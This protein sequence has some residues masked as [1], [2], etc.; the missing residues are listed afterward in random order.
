MHD[1]AVHAS[2]RATVLGIELML[3]AA[4]YL[5]TWHIAKSAWLRAEPRVI[6]FAMVVDLT[7]TAAG[8]HWLLGVRLARVPAWTVIL[9]VLA[10]L[11]TS[12]R[13]LPQLASAGRL[14]VAGIALIEGSAVMLGVFKLRHFMRGYRAARQAEA[15]GFDAL[16]AGF[17]A[18][19]P[20][21]PRLAAWARLEAEIASLAWVGWFLDRRPPDG[22]N[23]FTHHRQSH[24]LTIIGVLTFLVIVEGSGVHL[25]LHS[26]GHNTAKWILSAVHGYSLIWLLGDAQAARLYRSALLL[27]RGEP[28]LALQV[29]L[30][31]AAEVPLSVITEIALGSWNQA[32]S[33]E[34]LLALQG[35]ANVKLSFAE[36]IAW[37]PRLGATKAVRALLVH[38]DQPDAFKAAL[39]HAA[40][41]AGSD[42][43]CT[44]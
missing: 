37:K 2:R 35:T 14:V 40:H 32:R 43:R 5:F 12:H 33:D 18:L 10:G 22:P 21:Y 34:G 13:L 11:V 9:V 24:W 30:R 16:E 3:F 20:S 23:V 15:G 39:T 17:S 4:L 44:S 7:L 36:P 31:G 42:A 29:G 28:W 1:D 19:A 8:C 41:E 6:G 26:T 25:W 38:V 27:K